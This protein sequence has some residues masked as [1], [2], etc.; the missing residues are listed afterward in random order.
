MIS[1]AMQVFQTK[2]MRHFV[3]KIEF[4][5]L[6]KGLFLTQEQVRE[7]G[8]YKDQRQIRRFV[9]GEQSPHKD[10]VDRLNELDR[11]IDEVVAY[12]VNR[13]IESKVTSVSV[14]GY[15]SSDQ[16][17]EWSDGSLPFIEL[18][19]CLLFRLKKALNKIG[20][21]C[22]VKPFIVES[23]LDFIDDNDLEDNQSSMAAWAASV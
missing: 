14:I 3:N 15:Q 9:S 23:Y 18:H 6:V 21:E 5:A 17:I 8:G 10:L 13:A 7:I 22:Q 1:E 20:I 19:L 2:F 16:F 12:S 4:K 11:S